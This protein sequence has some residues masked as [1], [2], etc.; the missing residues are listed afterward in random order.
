MQ[1]RVSTSKARMKL[2]TNF[3]AHKEEYAK[4]L[5]GWQAKM[6]EY[7]ADLGLWAASGGIEANKPSQPHKPQ[8]FDNVYKRLIKMLEMHVDIDVTIDDTEFDQIFLDKFNWKHTFAANSTLYGG[9]LAAT[10]AAPDED[11]DI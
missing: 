8:K 3:E 1:I 9:S 10:A 11:D 2:Q 6:K 4:Q 5:E 7:S